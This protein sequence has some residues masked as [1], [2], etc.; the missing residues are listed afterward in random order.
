MGLFKGMEY[1]RGLTRGATRE[2]GT[3]VN[4]TVLASSVGQMAANMWD[5]FRMTR[6][7]GTASTL[8]QAARSTSACGSTVNNMAME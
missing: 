1:K 8:G 4:I 3:R 6:N 7:M 5:N 2:N